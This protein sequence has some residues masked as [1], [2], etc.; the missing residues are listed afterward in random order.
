LGS[1]AR[2]ANEQGM[3]ADALTY[4]AEAQALSRRFQSTPGLAYS[5]LERGR[6]LLGLE[7]LQEARVA[8]QEARILSLS[9]HQERTAA[10]ATFSLGRLA[11][12]EG[13]PAEALRQ[14]E[15]A[16]PNYQAAGDLPQLHDAY[17]L[18]VPLL[19]EQGELAR[20][21]ALAE[22][23]LDLLE[24]ISGREVSRRIALIEYR[25]QA[26]ASQRQ[27]EQLARENEI[28]ALR[29]ERQ[30]LGRRIA[31]GVIAGLLLVASGLLWM[32]RRSQR[33]AARLAA[34]NAELDASRRELATA[35]ARLAERAAALQVAATS[36]ALTGIANRRH[37]LATLNEVLGLANRDDLDLAVLLLDVD[38]FKAINDLHGHAVGDAVLVGVVESV[39]ALLPPRALL[40]RY[41]GEEFL[42]VLPEHDRSDALQLADLLLAAV[43]SG[44]NVA[45]PRVTLSIGVAARRRGEAAAVAALIEQADRALYQA[46]RAGRDRAV[47]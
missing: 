17:L 15:A 23:S 27:I 32:Y 26:Q 5:A 14:F 33:I 6:A 1:L 42:L 45:Q 4:A 28:K 19:R 10:D 11:L 13:D 46:K 7:R 3:H 34:S 39:S 21:L 40:G 41:G 44:A 37:V 2:V 20:A 38:R 31:M 18:M 29:L 47:G 9:I 25:Y 12:K 22:E 35:N 30:E 43:R 16:V 24:Q 8:L 36:D